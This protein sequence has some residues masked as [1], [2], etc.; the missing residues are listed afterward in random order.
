VTTILKP[1]PEELSTILAN[2]GKWLRGEVGGERANLAGANL[3]GA[4]LAGANLYGASLYGASLYGADLTRANLG[5]A[6]L[7][8]ADLTRAN[9]YGANLYG[10]NLTRAS[11]YGADLTRANLTRATLPEGITWE[12]Y[13]AEVVPALLAAGGKAVADVLAAGAWDCH[14]WTN[15]PMAV[16]FGVDSLAGVPILLRPRANEFVR[17]FD[18]RLIPMPR[19]LADGTWTCLPEP[20]TT[21]ATTTTTES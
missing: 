14:Q 9:L 20:D 4:Y 3:T 11:L 19:Q 8:R 15:C 16:A 5:G 18:A 1:D 13:L 6:N 12:Q 17:F 21:T 10:A 2:N 7:T